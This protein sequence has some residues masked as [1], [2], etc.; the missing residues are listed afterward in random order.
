MYTFPTHQLLISNDKYQYEFP[1]VTSI[2]VVE[3]QFEPIDKMKIVLPPYEGLNTTTFKWGNII[4]L[5]QF[6]YIEQ[7]TE[8]DS[9]GKVVRK[10]NDYTDLHTYENFIIE[11]VSKDYP[12][13]I[14]ANSALSLLQF[15]TT[16]KTLSRNKTSKQWIIELLTKIVPTTKVSFGEERGYLEFQLGRIEKGIVHRA[17]LPINGRSVLWALEQIS[18]Q[19][20]LPYYFRNNKFHFGYFSDE[21]ITSDYRKV[22]EW[23]VNII[24]KNHIKINDPLDKKSIYTKI[25]SEKTEYESKSASKSKKERIEW[26]KRNKPVHA[27]YPKSGNLENLT[28]YQ[29][30][31]PD[32]DQKEAD[33]RAKKYF[34]YLTTK[35]YEGNLTIPGYP[36]LFAG[37]IVYI[38]LSN[39]IGPKQEVIY[40]NVEINRV[41]KTYKAAEG[42]RQQIELGKSWDE[43]KEEEREKE[44]G[45]SSKAKKPKKHKGKTKYIYVYD[46]KRKG[47]Y[48]KKRNTQQNKKLHKGR[49]SYKR[50]KSTIGRPKKK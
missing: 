5:C 25:F 23:G 33:K 20:G 43:V 35:R 1:D 29:K 3:D 18:E 15:I 36:E 41:T 28:Q 31:I 17:N 38:S 16:T 19:A 24:D 11:N 39:R 6:G 47:Y 32:I 37:E 7:I 9:S 34:D 26:I 21:S 2:R 44:L 10:H 48:T 14:E 8:I 45:K 30:F 13:T 12:I 46:S 27:V 40:D 49:F 42:I 50:G 22:L 4:N